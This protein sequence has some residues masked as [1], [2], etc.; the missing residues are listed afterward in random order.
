MDDIDLGGTDI[1][2]NRP[3]NPHDLHEVSDSL[4]RRIEHA[5]RAREIGCYYL[6]TESKGAAFTGCALIHHTRAGVDFFSLTVVYKNTPGLDQFDL[7]GS[8]ATFAGTVVTG[9][10]T[11]R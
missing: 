11:I 9:G 8:P 4:R 3:G 6:T 7:F 5:Q 1:P 10:V 2:S